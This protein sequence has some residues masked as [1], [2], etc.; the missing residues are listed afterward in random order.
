MN[1]FF[2][3]LMG[4]VAFIP[5]LGHRRRRAGT[6]MSRTTMSMLGRDSPGTIAVDR[7][8]AKASWSRRATCCS[9]STR[10]S[11][12][13]SSTPRRRGPMRRRRRSQNLQTGSRQEEIDVTQASLDKAQADLALAQQN[14]ARTQDLFDRGL[15][16]QSQARPGQGDACRR[17]R[18][19]STSCRRSSR[20]QQLPA[21]DA[22]QIAAEAS[23]AAAKA[24][25]DTAKAALDD[26]TVTA[27]EDGRIERLFFKAGEVAG[28]GAPVLSLQRRRRAEGRVLRQ[29]GRPA[30][31]RA[32]PA[33]QRQLR[34]LRRRASP[35]RSAISPP[36]RS[37]RRRSSI[38][39]TS[40]T[41]WCS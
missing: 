12:R 31:V 11:S 39:A 20:W 1:G 34:R 18:R 9:C 17:R 29:R 19:R 40:A 4:L 16:P 36:T 33:G 5:G 41:G 10:A 6:A 3:W 13:R 38:R 37:S 26:R 27:P 25:A 23:L 15:T 30:A 24:D 7:G 2:A 35:R 21:R 28:A 8:G 22:Q 14:L 32:G